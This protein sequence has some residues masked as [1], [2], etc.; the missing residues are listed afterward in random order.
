MVFGILNAMSLQA[1]ATPAQVVIIRHAEK[2]PTGNEVNQQGCERAYGLPHFIEGNS[3]VEQFGRP[4]AL[5]AAAPKN[6][7]SSIRAIQTLAPTAQA[8]QIKIR[9]TYTKDDLQAAVDEISQ[10]STL[11]SQTVVMAWEHN[12]IPDL[13]EAFGA[14]LTENEQS[15]PDEVFDQAWV[16]RFFDRQK[17]EGSSPTLQ[18][19]PERVLPTD[20]PLGGIDHWTDGPTETASGPSVPDQVVQNCANNVSLDAVMEQWITSALQL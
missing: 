3:T 6:A 18:I 13:A 12:M 4:A 8:L 11:D 7:G 2:P 15:W 19:I 16:I 14:I 17:M 20:N 9:D 5:F 10:D 1:W